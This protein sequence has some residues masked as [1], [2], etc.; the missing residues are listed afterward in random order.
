MGIVSGLRS[1]I[2]IGLLSRAIPLRNK[3]A[4]D[5]NCREVKA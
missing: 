4:A 1:D 5:P 2:L 3:M